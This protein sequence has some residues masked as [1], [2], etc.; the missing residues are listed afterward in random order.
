MRNI[1][2]YTIVV[3]AA[4][5]IQIEF[6]YSFFTNFQNLTPGVENSSIALADIDLDGHLDLIMTGTDGTNGKFRTYKNDGN[7]SFS[8]FSNISP[9]V[10][11]RSIA[12]GDI[13]SD[14]DPDLVMTGEDG[15]SDYFRTYLNNG[16]GI[17]SNGSGF[18]PGVY[19]SSITL[20]DIDSDGDLDLIMIGWDGSSTYCRIYKNDGNGYFSFDANI[21]SGFYNGS[22]VLGDVDSDNDLDLILAA[23]YGSANYFRVYKNNG[24][25]SFSFYANIAS[26]SYLSSIAL[27]D[28]D[29]DGDLDLI[30]SGGGGGM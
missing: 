6:A 13:D 25:G 18:S 14:G 17:F 11:Y 21:A 10:Y 26:P 22:I 7:G 24:S 30:M 28:I 1:I 8:F 16:N 20:G 19:N 12:S 4:L 15:S 27:G 2:R 3:L 9:G 29:S 23:R 5:F